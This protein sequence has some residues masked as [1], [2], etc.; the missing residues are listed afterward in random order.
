MP[1]LAPY[2]GVR[3]CVHVEGGE[4]RIA[5]RDTIA[6]APR[7]DLLQAGPLLVRDGA[8]VFDR[9]RDPEG[10]S[11]GS[12]QFD[13]DITAGRHPRA[14]LAIA[15]GRTARRRLRRPLAPG[16]R[17]RARRARGRARGPR[18]RE[19]INLDGGGSTSLVVGGRL[20]NRPRATPSTPEPGGRP[21]STA[22]L[23]LPRA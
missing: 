1:F 14:A 22:L 4:A 2:D 21:I 19:A 6:A 20:R 8:V 23:F 10:F 17:P 18:A 12:V 16:G 7:G 5:R 9:E 13:S 15:P 11:A 3:A